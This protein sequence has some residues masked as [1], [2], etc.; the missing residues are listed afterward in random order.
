VGRTSSGVTLQ[1][2]EAILEKIAKKAEFGLGFCADIR[3][4]D[5][6]EYAYAYDA[7]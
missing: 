6:R 5:W 7:S 3:I 2:N 1:P 4:M